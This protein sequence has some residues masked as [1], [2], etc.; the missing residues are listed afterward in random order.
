MLKTGL[1]VVLFFPLL[2]SCLDTGTNNEIQSKKINR[3]RCSFALPAH[4]YLGT[5]DS[6]FDEQGYFRVLSERSQNRMQ[7]F[8]YNSKIDIDEELKGKIEA[9]NSRDVFTARSIDS[10]NRFGDYEGKGVIMAGIYNG[11][12][13][14]GKIKIFCYSN[15][16]KGFVTIRQIIDPK[17]SSSF[18]L[19]EKSFLL[20]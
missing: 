11:G 1:F 15:D 20:K 13:V 8:V 5:I 6:S 14:K 9:L 2:T 17:D 18:N 3:E 12:I 16:Q 10:V 7:L 19:V 4:L